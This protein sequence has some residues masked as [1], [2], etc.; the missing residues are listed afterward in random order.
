MLR[1]RKRVYNG[2]EISFCYDKSSGLMEV[3]VW[4][5]ITEELLSKYYKCG[6]H[7]ILEYYKDNSNFI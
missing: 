7:D 6:Y 4:N 5:I 1:N 3:R 2:K